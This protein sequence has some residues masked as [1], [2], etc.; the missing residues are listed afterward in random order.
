MMISSGIYKI[1]CLK[2]NK[3]YIGSSLNIDR[4]L[5]AHKKLLNQNKHTNKYLQ[6]SW[7]K[8]GEQNFKFEIIETIHDT[9]QLLIREQW[10][11]D[12]TN[13]YERK[14]GFNVSVDV[15]APNTGKFIN[16]TGQ[17]FGKL[18]PIQ[19]IGK[20]K[21]GE[22]LWLCECD[23]GKEKI[24]RG[25]A[26]SGGYTKSCGCLYIKKTN[27]KHG[28]TGSPTYQSWI[29]INRKCNN[30]DYKDYKNY[31]EKG[32]RVCKRWSDKNPNGFK[33]FLTDM[34]E[35]PLG[36]SLYRIDKNKLING[37]SPKNCRWDTQKQQ[38]RNRTNNCLETYNGKTQC[39]SAFAE[40]YNIHKDTLNYR[41]NKKKMTIEE[42]LIMPIRK[43]KTNAC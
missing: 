8:Y 3:F 43:R 1:I 30:S 29:D 14:I 34:G 9:A 2:N 27:F 10:W 17:K 39:R 7:N 23:C 33:N 24:V 15:F 19:T 36:L 6:N 22:Y 25:S 42:A 4:R 32:V 12:N 41:L 20:N 21:H 13:C 31:G 28:Y 35:R 5:K 11:L 38:Q 18:T 26:L 37:I 16:L 40:E